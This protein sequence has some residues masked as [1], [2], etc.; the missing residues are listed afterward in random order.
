MVEAQGGDTG[1]FDDRSRLPAAPL[2]QEVL[3]EGDGYV[4][5]L[6]ALAVARAS[7]ALGARRERKGDPIDLSVGVVL[8]AKLGDR[9]VKGQPLA[10]LHAADSAR[11]TDAERLFRDGLVISPEPL[12]GGAPPLI[13]E[14]VNSQR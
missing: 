5:R 4:S 1:A 9:V 6:D 2:R 3:A 7:I 12:D 13:L 14:R 11:A 8:A 10:T